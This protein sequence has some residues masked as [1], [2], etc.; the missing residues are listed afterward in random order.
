MLPFHGFQN[1]V[2]P[3]IY[4]RGED[5]FHN[6]TVQDIAHSGHTWRATVSGTEDYRVKL[7]IKNDQVTE[8]SC[9][10]PYEDG[11]VCKHVVA[12]LLALQ[13]L[14]ET[15]GLDEAVR[16]TNSRQSSLE[17]I[18]NTLTPE[19]LKEALLFSCDHYPPLR[20]EL[21]VRYMPTGKDSKAQITARVKKTLRQVQGY[22]GDIPWEER[23]SLASTFDTFL[24]RA[25][26]GVDSGNYR[27]AADTALALVEVLLPSLEE[28]D[29]S[30]GLLGG[31]VEAAFD[32][33]H[34]LST[35]SLPRPMAKEL[36]DYFLKAYKKELGTG[37]DFHWRWL[38]MA[39]NL[40]QT[41]E[42][43]QQLLSI[44]DG[45]R[46][47]STMDW[48]RNYEAGQVMEVKLALF[49]KTRTPEEVARLEEEN[50]RFPSI[51]RAAVEDAYAA[52]D[53]E[54]VKR[55]CRDGIR[56][57]QKE[58]LPGLV[59]QWHEWLL[60]VAHAEKDKDAQITQA[61]FLL[62]HNHHVLD[63]YH[64]LKTLLPFYEWPE[65]RERYLAIMKKHYAEHAIMQ[66]LVE[67]GKAEELEAIIGER[68]SLDFLLSYEKPLLKDYP[69]IV[70]RQFPPLV[71]SYM[72]Q[73][74]GRDHYQKVASFLKRLKKQLGKEAV[75]P[76]ATELRTRYRN[77]RA[78]LEE[79]EGV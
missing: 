23:Q 47:S 10:C 64:L 20:E 7:S 39:V 4:H 57:A 13:Q 52:K 51:R 65:R 40:V 53:W 12:L 60:K 69:D 73:L 45:I 48:Y 25:R 37:F 16:E 77:R 61:E 50:L 2:D 44:L 34:Q 31:V 29:D 24:D 6:D 46:S 30:D 17:N 59:I 41:K 54:K 22:Y 14:D 58:Q 36:F 3:K 66:I 33:L 68:A 78:L 5:Y 9:T 49:R 75:E 72:A 55:L 42:E 18:L 63:C 43:E 35:S 38:E 70:K 26:D 32:V 62:E 74:T 15:T 11:P 21:L 27:Q 1:Y 67:E 71:L 76:V 56:Q 8:W 79:L 19:Q 28:I